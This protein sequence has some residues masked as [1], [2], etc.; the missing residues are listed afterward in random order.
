MSTYPDEAV[1]V[2]AGTVWVKET[3]YTKRMS[4]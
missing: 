4:K 3:P 2:A 1:P